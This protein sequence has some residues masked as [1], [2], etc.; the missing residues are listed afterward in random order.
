[1]FTR[2][3]REGRWSGKKKRDA[4]G[5]G[6]GKMIGKRGKRQREV[7][8]EGYRVAD[9]RARQYLSV[10]ENGVGIRLIEWHCNF[11]LIDI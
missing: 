10:P 11:L 7:G 6:E 8:R 4:A 3:G 9:C 2:K 1:M 5:K